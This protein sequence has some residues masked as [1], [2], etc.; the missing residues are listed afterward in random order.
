MI[1]WLGALLQL[2]G[3]WRVASFHRDAFLWA[4]A[5]KVLWV[6][7]YYDT[8]MPV[9]VLNV[10]AIGFDFRAWRLWSAHDLPTTRRRRDA[11]P[12][13]RR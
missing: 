4:I 6:A 3:R 13:Y 11:V 10:I 7:W 5:G 8:A 12:S 9:V 1:G 2:V